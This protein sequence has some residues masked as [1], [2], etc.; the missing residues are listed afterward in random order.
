[1]KRVAATEFVILT[2]FTFTGVA[3]E[4]FEFIL[5]D[6]FEIVG[7]DIALN[8]FGTSFDIKAGTDIAVIHYAGGVDARVTDEVPAAQLTFKVSA[9][10]MAASVNDLGSSGKAL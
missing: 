3:A 6:G 1:M 4:R 2:A 8:Q 10:I 9:E 7:A 5:P